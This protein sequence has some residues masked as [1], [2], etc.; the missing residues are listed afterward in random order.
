MHD[1]KGSLVPYVLLVDEHNIV[2]YSHAGELTFEQ[3]QKLFQE[4][5]ETG[6]IL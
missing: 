3:E 1:L 2:R 6:H 5:H 4:F